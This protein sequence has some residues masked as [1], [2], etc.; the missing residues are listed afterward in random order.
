MPTKMIKL[1]L[2]K[3][4]DRVSSLYLFLLLIHI[5]FLLPLVKW[6]VGCVTISSF[7]V[8][9]NGSK[10]NFFK[11]SRG[12][13]HGFPLSPYLFLLVAKGLSRSISES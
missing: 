2:S 10:S 3:A 13:R 4:Y 6:T 12:L 5:G 7:V 11:S 1:Y 8:L 9:I